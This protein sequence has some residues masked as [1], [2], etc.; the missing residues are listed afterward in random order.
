MM[1]G[2]A[3]LNKNSGRNM[4]AIR[5]NIVD[6]QRSYSGEAN[7]NFCDAVIAALSAE[8]E[9]FDELRNAIARF[10][11]YEDGSDPFSFF[12]QG[13]S[14]EPTEAEVVIIDLAARVIAHDSSCSLM[15]GGQILY[16]GPTPNS[17]ETWLPY[18]IPSDWLLLSSTREYEVIRETRTNE[19]AANPPTDPRPVL[20]GEAMLDFILT[21]TIKAYRIFASTSHSSEA[22]GL[23]IGKDPKAADTP[24]SP[25]FETAERSDR[26]ATE[27]YEYEASPE[28]RIIADIHARWLMTPR[29][30]LGGRTPR[31]FLVGRMHFIGFDLQY[32]EYQWSM[33]REGPPPLPR[34][35]FAYKHAG[36]GTH[37]FVV[38]Y[39]LLRHL[40]AQCWDIA[41]T[42][43]PIDL[44]S[45]LLRLKQIEQTWLDARH[46][47]FGGR[48][49]AEIIE[50]ERRR[51]PLIMSGKQFMMDEG[52]EWDRE[53]ATAEDSQLH[54]DIV[55]EH[56]GTA[57]EFF[58]PDCDLCRMLADESLDMG[59][60]FWHL[61]CCN[62]DEGFAFS[63]CETM[64][65]WEGEERS[66]K[67]FNE[68]FARK[69]AAG[70]F[71]RDDYLDP[72]EET[73]E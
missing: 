27:E 42:D 39:D 73:I 35:S 9:T 10:I 65:E 70:E 1:F 11:K 19:R 33:L 5:L 68:E 3:A 60:G 43:N 28:Y 40:L 17:E 13:I 45:E 71:D 18:L 24:N 63:T 46:D 67:E 50:S 62:M 69:L 14:K 53:P 32:R 22:G 44:P 61:D 12:A 57:D 72:L 34:D 21:E 38:Y 31:Q 58:H 55:I 52:S 25:S 30:D 56:G 4:N 2:P 49:P 66:R 8:P 36:F 51:I 29:D 20:Y 23:E 6:G 54:N 26:D 7:C 59:P 37:E 15:T 64:E 41:S 48:V 16:L 47:D